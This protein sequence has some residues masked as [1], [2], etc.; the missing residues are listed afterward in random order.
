MK[1]GIIGLGGIA[2]KAYLPVLTQMKDVE[3]ILST[4]NQET[5]K[6]IQE[7]YHIQ[8]TAK[9]LDD[10]ISMKPD[11]IFVCSATQVHFEM[12]EKILKAG[13]AVHL[14]KPV[15]LYL[16]EV[17]KLSE[18]AK[19][20]NVLFVVGFNRRFVPLVEKVHALGVP[21]MVI[22]QKNRHLVEDEIRRFVTDDFVH[23]VDTT[24]YLLQA[25]V[26]GIKVY[27]KFEK[28]KLASI[29]VHMNTELNHAVCV[30]N[31]LNGATEEVIEVM[32]PYQKSIIRNL[33]QYEVYQENKLSIDLPNDWQAT[34]NKR[35]FEKMI[36]EFIKTLSTN[37]PSIAIDDALKTH[38][39]CEDIIQ[40]IETQKSV[41][42]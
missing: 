5:L 28:D 3:L 1:I 21:D 22:Y 9:D 32:H 2:Q 36:A 15:S 11:A 19:Q 25:E 14:D 27:P 8:S 20:L 23:V 38:Q 42:S 7:K 35:G 26:K 4:R 6:S 39:I 33:A 10:L 24:R 29:I 12:T 41:L 17:E 34:L 13:I 40:Q 18:L 31:Y 37:Q 16:H 30:M